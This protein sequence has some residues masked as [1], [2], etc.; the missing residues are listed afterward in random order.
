M[1]TKTLNNGVSNAQ[2]TKKELQSELEALK[3]S[4]GGV[5]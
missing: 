3:A 4:K 2:N 5:K 1:T